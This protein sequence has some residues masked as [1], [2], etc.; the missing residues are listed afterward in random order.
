MLTADDLRQ[1]GCP[2]CGTRSFVALPEIRRQDQILR[3]WE[4]AIGRTFPEETYARHCADGRN[5]LR[6]LR[7]EYCAGEFFVPALQGDAAFYATIVD[8]EM[9]YYVAH[10]KWEFDY[11]IERLRAAGVRRV[12]DYGSGGGAFLRQAMSAIPSMEPY[13]YDIGSAPADRAAY[14]AIDTL[15]LD[16]IDGEPLDAIVIMQVLEHL[17]TPAADLRRAVAL[18]RSGGIVI[19]AVPD[20]D[21]PT[22][23]FPDAVTNLPP[24]HLSRWRIN[25][26]G[27]LGEACGLAAKEIFAEPLSSYLWRSYVPPMIANAW[28]RWLSRPLLASGLI[29]LLLFAMSFLPMRSLPFVRGHSA[30]A[31]FVKP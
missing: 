13:G 16:A 20:A 7:C 24:H 31:L 14:R 12:L 22:A 5:E 6:R 2:V 27:K 18:L 8:S 3:R 11:A 17:E 30:V 15:T 4:K 19:A 26:L 25:T 1:R 28:P 23:L 9:E 21:G 10:G 29:D